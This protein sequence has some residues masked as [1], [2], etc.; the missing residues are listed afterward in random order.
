MGVVVP[1]RHRRST[2]GQATVEYIGAVALVTAV[3]TVAA[4]VVPGAPA[5]VLHAIPARLVHGIRHGIC[6]VAGDVCTPSEA[7][8]AG[9]SP[10]VV[11]SATRARE[12]EASFVFFRA[13]GGDA[14]SVSQDSEGRITVVKRHLDQAG[15]QT[16]AELGL[17]AFSV[18]ADAGVSLRVATA[19][20]WEFP[21]LQHARSF[22]AALPHSADAP[23]PY[24]V[25]RSYEGGPVADAEISATVVGHTL[26]GVATALDG[27]A[28]ARIGR[29][30][31]VTV[32][33]KGQLQRPGPS[34]DL[35][36]GP[37][38]NAGN[39]LGEL[40]LVHGEPRSIA[41]TRVQAGG[42]GARVVETVE[43]LDLRDP[44]NRAAAEQVLRLKPPWPPAAAAALF[45]RMAQAGTVERATYRVH[46]HS[47]D[48]DVGIKLGEEVG[49]KVTVTRNERYLQDAAAWTPGSAERE[50]FDCQPRP[51]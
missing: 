1:P 7:A 32:Y 34:G 9:L 16:G 14:F 30:G 8:A 20:A 37:G 2:A 42:G 40:T 47:T 6:I 26:T 33:F 17:G 29:G 13:G 28:G 51:Q 22:I 10:C 5:P 25:W 43:R 45:R 50:R 46:D 23:S 31:A 24:V 21:D 19:T 11:T 3:L 27:S 49:L 12:G 36:W 35:V 48:F 41:F 4:A 18:G 38:G 44:A 15:L 39:V